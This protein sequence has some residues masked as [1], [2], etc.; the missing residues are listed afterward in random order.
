MAAGGGRGV[1]FAGAAGVV[2]GSVASAAAAA[3]VAAENIVDVGTT[4]SFAED[5]ER[6]LLAKT[7]GLRINTDF[8]QTDGRVAGGRDREREREEDVHSASTDTSTGTSLAGSEYLP[9]TSAFAD[10]ARG[11]RTEREEERVRGLWSGE[12]SSVV[13][14]QKR[15]LRGLM[16]GRRMRERGR[17][18]GAMPNVMANGGGAGAGAGGGGMERGE[19]RVGLGIV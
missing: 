5:V 4:T 11:E 10:A 19:G 7:Q 17:S 8:T 15:G 1:G 6:S 13:G 2:N 9:S 12:V 18:A 3:A 14:L 16:E